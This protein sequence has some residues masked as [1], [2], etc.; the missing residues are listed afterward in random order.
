MLSAPYIEF[1]PRN[2]ALL[3]KQ[4]ARLTNQ[5]QMLSASLGEQV[6]HCSTSEKSDGLKKDN[7]YNS[8]QYFFLNGKIY[9]IYIYI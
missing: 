5:N 4:E 6:G 7:T 3:R 1:S 9:F 8:K 2:E